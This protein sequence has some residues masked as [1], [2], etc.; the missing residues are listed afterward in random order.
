MKKTLRTRD[1]FSIATGAMIG[2]GFF[3]LPGIAFAVAG[4]AV[5]IA[6]LLAAILMI[7]TLLSNAEL[8]T[9][10]PRSGGSYFFV[11]RSMGPMAGVIDG[12]GG[13]LAMVAKSAFALVG[14]GFYVLMATHGDHTEASA[15][16]VLTV[17]IIAVAIAVLL[18]VVNAFGAKESAVFQTILVVGLVALSVYFIGHGSFHLAV[19]RFAGFGAKGIWAIL[20]TSGLV[21]VSYAG[22]NKVA[23]VAEEVQDPEKT[24]P[25]GMFLS[26]GT[27]TVIYVVGVFVVVG[28]VP[29]DDL[30]SDRTP[31][32]TAAGLFAGSAGVWAMVSAGCLAFVTTANAGVMSA[33][34]YLHAMGRDKVLPGVFGR[35][36]NRETPLWGIALSTVAVVMVV[37]F[38]DAEGIAKLAS[39]IML[40]E[41]AAM[42]LAVIV[43]RESR[44]SSYDSGFRSPLYPWMQV[45]GVLVSFVLVPLMG[46][47]SAAFALSLIAAGLVWY[48]A[49]AHGKAEHAVAVM[50]VM[51]RIAEEI[52]SRESAAP[53][54]DRELREIMK[55]KGL[56]PEDPFVEVASRAPII[57]LPDDAEWDDLMRDAVERLS[58]EHP[59]HADAIAD[60]FLEAGRHGKTPAAEGIALPHILLDGIKRYE[61]IA[62]RSRSG[63]HFPGVASPVHAVF[64]L[65]GCRDDPQQ[66]LRMLARIA[67]RAEEPRFLARWAATEDVEDLRA[68]LLKGDTRGA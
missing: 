47:M 30:A 7:P 4:P 33:S 38:L 21:F 64:V 59:E 8:A 48:V 20:A 2:S 67:R 37:L 9:A 3:L 54:L 65:L 18:A 49:Y 26:L 53:A 15:N 25:R 34:R 32:A 63:L 28:V 55:E 24:I 46:W 45:G 16:I 11:S 51:E 68:L 10:M 35:L 31:L 43:M 50:R 13:W 39:T 40:V 27:A 29:A 22:L 60:A 23:S 42:N 62:A 14:I 19:A 57:D 17:R 44:T 36:S 66:H 5:V 61:L 12:L 56:R 6:Y 41:F 58:K 52:L 1:V